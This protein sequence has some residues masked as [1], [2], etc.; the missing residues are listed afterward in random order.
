M[1]YRHLI[2]LA[3]LLIVA[4]SCHREMPNDRALF[5]LQGNV[6]ELTLSKSSEEMP[7]NNT[8]TITFSEK[9][10]ITN[11]ATRFDITRHYGALHAKGNWGVDEDHFIRFDSEGRLAEFRSEDRSLPEKVET[12]ATFTYE[13]SGRLPKS[14]RVST[15]RGNKASEVREGTCTYRTDRMGNWIQRTWLG[16]NDQRTIEYYNYDRG[17]ENCPMGQYLDWRLVIVL[18]V[19]VLVG[20]PMLLHML[21]ETLLRKQRDTYT[22]EDFRAKREALGS[23]TDSTLQENERARKY[24]A[25]L[26]AMWTRLGEEDDEEQ[27]PLKH[28]IIRKSDQLLCQ[29]AAIRPTDGEIVLDMNEASEVL[30]AM[31]RRVFSGSWLFV[32][33]SLVMAAGVTLWT[34][35]WFYALVGVLS[36]VLY[37]LGS[38]RPVF[39]HLRREMR[40]GEHRDGAIALIFGTIFGTLTPRKGRKLVAKWNPDARIVEVHGVER[41]IFT[42]LS[43]VVVVVMACLMW[44]VAVINYI[45][46]YLIY[47]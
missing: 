27:V 40:L 4:T 35:E 39:M 11:K 13:G 31:E 33:T 30:N 2:L 29:V 20:L 32:A 34:D 8:H 23:D 22:V 25:E 6:K 45:R 44:F 10:M 36:A 46:N 16:M 41:V 12:E 3:G 38:M 14:M 7:N 9:G 19:A 47:M 5:N 21:R 17:V 37:G 26:R 24:I 15:T 28:S 43:V 42:L 1:K 18:L